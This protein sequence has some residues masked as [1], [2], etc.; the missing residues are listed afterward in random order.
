MTGLADLGAQFGEGMVDKTSQR[1]I[2]Q[3]GI[4]DGENGGAKA[5]IA[6][7]VLLD[8]SAMAQC[9]QGALKRVC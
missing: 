8:K 6:M 5:V 2:A 9:R 1:F 3:M 7:L 4:G